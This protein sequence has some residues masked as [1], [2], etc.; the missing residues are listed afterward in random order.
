MT[1]ITELIRLAYE[2]QKRGLYPVFRIS[3]R[4]GT[5]DGGRKD[6]YR[7]QYRKRSVYSYKL[8]GA[9]CLF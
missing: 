7:M 8:R 9:D 4:S 1:E 3:D 5:G 2:A 6:F